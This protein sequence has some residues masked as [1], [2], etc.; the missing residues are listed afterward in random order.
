VLVFHDVVGLT[1]GKTPR[2]VKRYARLLPEMVDAVRAFAS[3]VRERRYP[4]AEHEYGM[5]EQ[6]LASLRSYLDGG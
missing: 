6:E 5:D 1:D 3:D 2:F 4:S